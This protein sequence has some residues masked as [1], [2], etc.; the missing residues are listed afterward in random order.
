MET[1]IIYVIAP[2]AVALVSWILGKNGRRIDETSK[3][4]GMQQEEL[5]RLDRKV[6]R[7]EAKLEAKDDA[8]DRKSTIIQAA[9]LCRTP[10]VKCPVLIKQNEFNQQK[11][12]DVQ[13]I[14]KPE[15]GEYPPEHDDLQGGDDKPRPGL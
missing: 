6:E 15:S 10:S 2:I 11:Y 8:L 7:L 12:N 1:W 14:E 5:K 3:L 13:R 4:V 9:F